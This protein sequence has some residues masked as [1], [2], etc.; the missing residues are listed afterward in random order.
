M[1]SGPTTATFDNV[2]YYP[3]VTPK[4]EGLELVGAEMDKPFDPAEH[5]Y[6]AE[7]D[8]SV[9]SV[10]VIPQF[11]TCLLYTSRCV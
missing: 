9:D 11:D 3:A 6:W 5:S 8:H 1:V 10:S 4:L 2:N 7:V